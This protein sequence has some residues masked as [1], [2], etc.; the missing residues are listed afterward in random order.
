MRS[1][2]SINVDEYRADAVREAER[3]FRT[4]R[5][6]TQRHEARLALQKARRAAEKRRK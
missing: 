4:A 6:T 1:P 5:T 3:R 2:L